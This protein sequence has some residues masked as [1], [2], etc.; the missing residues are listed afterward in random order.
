M[1]IESNGLQGRTG[2]VERLYLRC[3]QYCSSAL[4]A[5]VQGQIEQ[6]VVGLHRDN[7]TAVPAISSEARAQQQPVLWVSISVCVCICVCVSQEACFHAIEAL[8]QELLAS[9]EKSNQAKK[10][11]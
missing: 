3:S 7:T 2:T 6:L 4:S 11:A 8:E 9:K 5:P 1:Q 10:Q